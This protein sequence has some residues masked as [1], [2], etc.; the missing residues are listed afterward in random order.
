LAPAIGLA[1]TTKEIDIFLIMRYAKNGVKR[2]ANT[3]F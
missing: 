1:G 2:K 3:P